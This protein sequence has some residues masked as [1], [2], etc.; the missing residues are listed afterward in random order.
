M[1]G[2]P[3][4]FSPM[5][6]NKTNAAHPFAELDL[7]F[8]GTIEL[9]S[10]FYVEREEDRGLRAALLAG[11]WVEVHGQRLIGKSSLVT[12]V[13]GGLNNG[14]RSSYVRDVHRWLNVDTPFSWCYDLA[15]NL[16]E[17]FRVSSARVQSAVLAARDSGPARWLAEMFRA[18]REEAGPGQLIVV[19]DEVDK[20]FSDVEAKI[21]MARPEFA[22]LLADAFR[23]VMLS[24]P[25]DI[26]VVFVGLN[27]FSSLVFAHAT[28]NTGIGLNLRLHDFSEEDWIRGLRTALPANQPLPEELARGIWRLTGG[29]PRLGQEFIQLA[30]DGKYHALTGNNVTLLETAWMAAQCAGS[31][32]FSASDLLDQPSLASKLRLRED[33]VSIYLNSR[34]SDDTLRLL[35]NCQGGCPETITWK[36]ALV[37]DINEMLSDPSLYD[38]DRF[39]GIILRPETRRLL[40]HRHEGK[41]QQILN[42]MLLEDAYP[43]EI[44][45]KLGTVKPAEPGT[46]HSH[47]PK[48]SPE[49]SVVKNIRELWDDESKNGSAALNDK[50]FAYEQIL[51]GDYTTVGKQPAE[52][53]FLVNT[54]LVRFKERGTMEK[55][56]VK[57][58]LLA[59]VFNLAWVDDLRYRRR[60]LI[61]VAT[62]REGRL[63]IINTGGTIGMRYDADHNEVRPTTSQQFTAQYQKVFDD[64]PADFVEPFILD[65]I[66]VHPQDW[67]RL[68]QLIYDRRRLYKGFVVPHGT[69]T[70]AYTASAVAFALGPFL[71]RPVVFTGAQATVDKIHGDAI[72]NLYRAC[73][74]AHKNIP[75]VVIAFGNHVFRACRAQKM[76]EKR[77]EAF[78][79]PAYP[80]LAVISEYVELREKYLRLRK[81]KDVGKDWILRP[82]FSR[83]V[84]VIQLSPGMGV[85]Y[86]DAALE[87]VNP[88][89]GKKCEGVII[90]TLGSGNIPTAPLNYAAFIRRV[91]ARGI[92]V[93]IS[94]QY[95]WHPETHER[96]APGAAGAQA[97]AILVPTMTPAA[98]ETKF[99][100][101]LAELGKLEKT[102]RGA[103]RRTNWVRT[104]MQKN[105]VDEIDSY[106]H[107]SAGLG[108][109]HSRTLNP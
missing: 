109:S 105:I 54:G 16:A 103:V 107:D 14:S 19:L 51:A 68:A 81:R 67:S 43:V 31:S 69:D 98:A 45:R 41:T 80:A 26:S 13:I 93:L 97:G 79:S 57:A 8:L 23:A 104:V 21:H 96:F 7:E 76:D 47:V 82:G 25:K 15:R 4:T 18:L 91:V 9:A 84:L 1:L 3:Q 42:R 38:R 24:R 95:P 99:R 44:L 64:F 35:A 12:R 106:P 52:I 20:L 86:F 73:L 100:W 33:A 65:S 10:K 88:D 55:L 60:S 32:Q 92:P 70:M 56:E 58:P 11:H 50:L 28:S 78:E 90:R 6:A 27:R 34:L 48:Y 83:D 22:T 74:V 87:V 75:E 62:P 94:S 108:S 39:A 85:H 66:N 40:E 37:R 49:S 36:S 30:R 101:A 72:T 89:T 59:R 29:Q 61:H 63:L 102:I 17:D 77:F 53:D 2:N 71:D 5:P 46:S